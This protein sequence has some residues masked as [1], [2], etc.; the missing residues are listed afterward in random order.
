MQQYS[1]VDFVQPQMHWCRDLSPTSRMF[2]LLYSAD[3]A[4]VWDERIVDYQQWGTDAAAVRGQGRPDCHPTGGD[5]V[6]GIGG[7]E[8]DRRVYLSAP[9]EVEWELVLRVLSQMNGP[10]KS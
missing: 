7:Q 8:A 6:G 3:I 10:P 9:S 5:R 1:T 4:F 2:R